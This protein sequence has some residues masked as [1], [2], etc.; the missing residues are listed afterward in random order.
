MTLEDY[1]KSL[2]KENRE[3]RKHL[4]H[5]YKG[6]SN[7]WRDYSGFVKQTHR[8]EKSSVFWASILISFTVSFVAH[9]IKKS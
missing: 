3:L 4:N 7:T 6:T 5:K 2:V 9:F 1:R 8:P